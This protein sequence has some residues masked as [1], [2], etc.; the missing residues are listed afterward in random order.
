MHFDLV[1]QRKL[2]TRPLNIVSVLLFRR[3]SRIAYYY[4]VW[5]KASHT[6]NIK[7]ETLNLSNRGLYPCL[8][9][10]LGEFETVMQTRDAVKSSHDC[11][12]FFQLLECLD[13]AI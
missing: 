11:R 8:R 6:I 5:I 7:D 3:N 4:C 13:E 12:E 1:V 2:Q 10:E 9:G